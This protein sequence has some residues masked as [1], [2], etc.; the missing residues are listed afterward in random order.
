MIED[1]SRGVAN[2]E[3]NPKQRTVLGVRLH[4]PTQ[5]LGV[6]KRRQRPVDPAKHFAERNLFRRALQ[7]VAAVRAANAINDSR[8]LELQ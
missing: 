3:Q 8:A 6:L 7:L 2:V 4:A 5:G 1:S